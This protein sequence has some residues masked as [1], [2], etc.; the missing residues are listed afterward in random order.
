[1]T[2]KYFNIEKPL[3]EM[4]ERDWTSISGIVVP[5]DLLVLSEKKE[6]KQ[7]NKNQNSST[8]SRRN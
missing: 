3:E 1:M 6:K 4:V 7:K 8:S 5:N 2:K